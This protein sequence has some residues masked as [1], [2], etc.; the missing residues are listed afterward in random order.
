DNILDTNDSCNCWRRD[1]KPYARSPMVRII[2]CLREP[3]SAGCVAALGLSDPLLLDKSQARSAN[4]IRW[5]AFCRF[6]HNRRR[7][8]SRHCGGN[9]S[10]QCANVDELSSSAGWC[11][12]WNPS[13]CLAVRLYAFSTPT[14]EVYPA[15]PRVDS[16][17]HHRMSKPPVLGIACQ[18]VLIIAFI[19]AVQ[20]LLAAQTPRNESPSHAGESWR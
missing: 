20:P 3:L 2:P 13:G 6:V 7:C 5:R 18:I 1:S 19:L 4:E 12:R 10:L 17:N 9:H 15:I 8:R 11:M 16:H 14:A